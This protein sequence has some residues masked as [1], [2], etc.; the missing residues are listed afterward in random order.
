MLQVGGLPRTYWVLWTG[1]LIN[2]L[3][4]FVMPLLALYLTGERGLSV[5]QVGLVV[6]FYG[7][8][9]LLAGPVGGFF[10]DRAG[11]RSTLFAALVLGALAM[12]HLA[13]AR[14]A[15]HIA[16]AAFLLG[17]LGELYRPVVSAAI[18]DL[19]PPVDRARAY[20]ILYWAVNLGF[21]VGSALGGALSQY[22]WYLLFVGDA[23][24]TLAYAAIV[25]VRIP[26]TRPVHLQREARQ[27]LWA[28]LADRPFV[29]FC[30]LN[31]LVVTLFQQA[32]VTLP[33]DV[34]EHGLPPAAYGSLIAL[35]GVLIFLL[36]PLVS[37]LL[38]PHPR[39]RVLAAAALLVGAG[40]GMTGLVR[41]IPGYV[42]SIAV[43]TLGEIV[44]AGIGPAVAADAAPPSR[45]GAYQGLYHMSF[46]VAALG[47]PVAGSLVLGRLGPGAL[48]AGCFLLGAVCAAG[49]LAL[50]TLRRH[51]EDAEPH[52][53][54]G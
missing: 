36:Q 9:A 28:P 23:A 41:T 15:P 11:R 42:A 19:V 46:G 43:W 33:I 40:F 48:W 49:Q 16:A 35:N 8:G 38:S 39:H 47:A 27:P 51:G 3:G 21:A 1:A 50:G 54:A 2:R 4:G 7:A 24:T 26:E 13:F 10:A 22:G 31:S 12:L 52:P 5:E 29:V 17:L 45:R 18:A 14:S 32:F 44:M 53:S 6:S 37:R 20:G 25:W 34:R 30:I